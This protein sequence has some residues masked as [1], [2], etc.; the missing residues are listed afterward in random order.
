MRQLQTLR[1]N[2][3]RRLYLLLLLSLALLTRRAHGECGTGQLNVGQ[4]HAA[5]A[6]L[7]HELAAR[8]REDIVVLR[9]IDHFLEEGLPVLH[10]EKLERPHHWSDQ[11]GRHDG[12]GWR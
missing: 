4:W 5:V 12:I 11:A 2:V 10:P 7:V 1:R 9:V 8:R 3:V 6:R